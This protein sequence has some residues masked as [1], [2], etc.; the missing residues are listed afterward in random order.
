MLDDKKIKELIEEGREFLKSTHNDYEGYL[1]DQDL[2]KKQ[3]PLVKE[4]ISD[5]LI[6]LSLDFNDLQIEDLT[7]VIKNRKSSRVFTQK[8]LSLKQLSYLLWTT[9]GIRAIR[10]KSYATLRNVPCGGARHEFET[11]LLVNY[12][13]GL[14]PGRYH[15]LPMTHQLEY[16]GNQENIP[17]TIG[18]SL[19]DQVW[20]NKASVVFYWS[21]VA[22][23]AE[24]RYGITAHRVVLMDIGH[25]G[26]N[27][28]LA[29][30]ALGIGVCGV[31]AFKLDYCNK[32]FGL[33]GEEEYIIYTSPVGTIDM[34]N[35]QAEKDFYKF[36]EEEG[37]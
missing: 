8:N 1:S 37:L 4:A 28:Y 23:R 33:D 31:G 6:K 18:V 36:V 30:S 21:F 26:E 15:Y 20:A 10:G 24:W 34:T 19:Y 29:C 13:E 35:D 9:Q 7:S 5:D 2:K 16:L 22:Y 17:E 14:K 11:Y 3:P 25:V 12:V 32:M 27:L